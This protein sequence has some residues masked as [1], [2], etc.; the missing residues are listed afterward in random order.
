MR[1]EMKTVPH[2]RARIC[3]LAMLACLVVAAASAADAFALP[4]GVSLVRDSTG[5]PHI[6][7]ANAQLAMYGFGYAQMQDQ[8][9]YL[10]TLINQ[11]NGR[12]AA[13]RGPGC[14]P[15]CFQS[16]QVVHLLRIPESAEEKFGSLPRSSQQR[17]TA[18]AEGINAYIHDHPTALPA[19]ASPV[20]GQEV[21]AETEYRF[22]MAQA[23]QAATI[24][25]S[26]ETKAPESKV[27]NALGA[28]ASAT[29]NDSIAGA[30]SFASVLAEPNL[31][32]NLGASNDFAVAGSRTASGKPVLHGDPHLEFGGSQQWYTAQLVY[33]GVRLEGATFRG[34]P[35]IG[36][37][38]NEHVAWTETANQTTSNEQDVY[39]ETLNPENPNQ[40]LYGGQYLNM[41][42]RNVAIDVQTSPGVIE[43]INVKFRYTIHGPV[44][45]DPST[46]V[47]GTQPPP[48]TEHAMAA[49]MSQYGQVGLAT[50]IWAENEARSLT[51]FKQAMSL[52]Q[53]TQFNTLAAGKTNIFYVA[54]SRSGMVN[55]GLS[56][57]VPLEGSNPAATWLGI[58][59][60]DDLPQAENPPDGYYENANNSPQFTAPGQ[61][62]ESELPYYLQS[63]PS[64][65]ARSLRQT[66]LLSSASNFTL[67]DAERI[68][69]D[70]YVDFAPTL[71]ALLDQA[72]AVPGADPR[73]QNAA[74]LFDA[75]DNTASTEETAMPLFAT[76]VAGLKAIGLGFSIENPPPPTTEFTEAQKQ[77]ASKAMLVAYNGMVEKYGTYAVAYGKLHTFARGTL[78]APISGGS[79]ITPTLFLTGCSPTPSAVYFVPCSVTTGSSYMMNTEMAS[80]RYTDSLPVADTA[81]TESPYYTDN[82]DTYVNKRY[83][84]YPVTDAAVQEQMTS[85]LE[86]P[87]ATKISPRKGAASGGT[88]VTITGAG[89]AEATGVDFG[90]SAA[91]SFTVNSAISITAVSPAGSTGTVDVT[92]T[93]PSGT[94]S[95]SEHDR[96]TYL[97]PA[98][99]DVSPNTGPVGGG[100]NVTVSGSGFALGTS[101][102][103]F[104][105]G[106]VMA[107]SVNCTTTSVCTVVAPAATKA[108]PVAVSATVGT[109]SSKGTATA[110]QFSYE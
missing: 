80:D 92:V 84:E 10:L 94:T 19:W 13:T 21:L 110:D 8:G 63:P 43:P 53:L 31:K 86:L 68:G 30:S 99:T 71:K 88:A 87:R 76:W 23:N 9:E 7:A 46:S 42:V 40:Y 93:T 95:V 103:V 33:P 11:A 51:Q 16:D 50:E 55:A 104:K 29:P 79:S 74:R 67:A 83:R 1:S 36:M 97:R 4:P 38:R 56:L 102:T 72:A 85:T 44:I 41:E 96:F 52:D 100:T 49:T 81:N 48:S 6:Y 108:R 91:S 3:L 24:V 57:K 35:V 61:I 25:K 70:V 101:G 28:N 5:E 77:D 20:T 109:S 82:A 66:E 54:T 105:F 18:F 106:K 90:T 64:N 73:V 69:M 27:A 22:L 65:G 17:F 107:A 15:S 12:S 59:P 45:S 39:Q 34:L 62:Q 89:F 37:G 32:V 60:F 98:I 58:L 26:A 14:L 47:N 2:G 78:T 75:W